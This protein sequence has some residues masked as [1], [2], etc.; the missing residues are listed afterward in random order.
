MTEKFG[1]LRCTEVQKAIRGKVWDL[2][3]PQQLEEYLQPEIH[4]KC[5]SVAGAAARI[6][7]A[8]I[9]ESMDF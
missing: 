5:G 8:A 9:L 6:A 4:D 1:G 2:R 7:S 3:D